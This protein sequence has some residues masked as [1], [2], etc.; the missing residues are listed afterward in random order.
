M[1]GWSLEELAKSLWKRGMTMEPAE[2]TPE[3]KET[4]IWV[5][6]KEKD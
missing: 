3:W 1:H 4:D 6:L 5:D 2:D